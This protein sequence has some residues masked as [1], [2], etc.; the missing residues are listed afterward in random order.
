MSPIPF[1]EFRDRVLSLYSTGRHARPTLTRMTQVL[2]E[3]ESLGPA[4]T[5]DLTTEL[6]ARYVTARGPLANPNTTNGYLSALAA[7]CSYAVEEGWLDHRP[8]WRR[9]RPRPARPIRNRPRR[10]EEVARL[11]D[12]LV[13][14]RAESW[15]AHRLCALVWLVALTGARRNEALWLSVSDVD[16]VGRTVRIAPGLHHRLK[17]VQS[18][19]TIPLPDV[20][21]CVLVDWV[22]LTG[23]VWLFPGLRRRG[24]WTGGSAVSRPLGAIQRAAAEAGVPRLTV[25]SLRHS[26][27]SAAVGRWSLPVWLVQRVMGHSDS[28]TTELYLHL[29]DSPA[30]AAGM[31]PVRYAV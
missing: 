19:R 5:A 8:A 1:P 27:G 11:L 4:T 10:Y 28:R 29:E 25:H 26:F 23:S 14:H 2:R 20:L 9:V 31:K 24:P 30:I 15:E 13:E 16:M 22:P 17:T 6:M 3:L 12:H 7:A 21:V 18:E